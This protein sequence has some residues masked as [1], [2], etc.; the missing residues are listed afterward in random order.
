MKLS[1]EQIVSQIIQTQAIVALNP[2]QEE[3][4]NLDQET[5]NIILFSP[6]GSGKTLAYLSR[7]LQLLD[8]ANDGIQVLIV[9]PARELVLQIE[10]VFRS[11]KSGFKVAVAYGGHHSRTEQ[12]RLTEAPAVLIGTPGRLVDHLRNERIDLKTIKLIVLDEFDKSLEMGFQDDIQALLQ[13]LNRNQKQVFTSATKLAEFPSFVQVKQAETLDYTKDAKDINLVLNYLQAPAAS[14]GEVLFSL[15]ASF[16]KELSVIF[17]NHREA[18]DRISLFFKDLCLAH[19]CLHGAMEQIDRERNLIKFRTGS[20]HI[21]IA[22]DLAS[23]GLDIPEIN[24]VVHYQMPLKEDAFIHRNGRTAR[25]HAS[26]KAYVILGD[27]EEMPEYISKKITPFNLP[28]KTV[29]PEAPFFEC[30]YFS[31]GKTDKIS[32]GD[33]LGLLTKKAGLSSDEIG[34]ITITDKASFVGVKRSKVRQVLQQL[35]NEKLKKSKVKVQIAR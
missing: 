6:T 29:L 9:S 5:K 30:I 35:N 7:A 32:K 12:Q 17:C 11:L 24:H 2:M 19:A 8:E 34:L 27:D 15:V 13:A 28:A 1:Q 4:L 26:G 22:T 33:V 31:A 10:D 20:S 18:V 3:M 14:K 25:M 21:L 16:N 23:R